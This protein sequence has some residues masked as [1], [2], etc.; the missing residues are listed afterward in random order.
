M[1]REYN[2]VILC[3]IIVGIREKIQDSQYWGYNC[4]IFNRLDNRYDTDN[5]ISIFVHQF[6][7]I[8]KDGF[9]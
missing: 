9:Q 4:T 5:T 8:I 2:I 3:R 7:F 6:F 1:S